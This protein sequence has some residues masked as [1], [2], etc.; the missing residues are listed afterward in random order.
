M[1]KYP[2]MIHY[3]LWCE[4]WFERVYF[5]ELF[6]NCLQL[7]PNSDGTWDIYDIRAEKHLMRVS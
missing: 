1:N 3:P 5:E 4:P 6:N 2:K 7:Q